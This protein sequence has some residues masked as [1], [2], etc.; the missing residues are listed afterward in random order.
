M[1][2]QARS[3]GLIQNYQGVRISTSGRRFAID[4]A[5]IWNLTDAVGQPCGQAAT[6]ANWEYL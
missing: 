6:F 5:T 1:L 4:R 2:A 3:H